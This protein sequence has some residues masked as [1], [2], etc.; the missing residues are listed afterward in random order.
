MARDNGA[1]LKGLELIQDAQPVFSVRV[2]VGKDGEEA[3]DHH[4]TGKEDLIFLDVNGGISARVSRPNP[5]QPSRHSTQIEFY[6]AIEENIGRPRPCVL[7][8]RFDFRS[9]L[10][11]VMD[12]LGVFL[13]YLF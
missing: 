8:Q 7:P 1:R 3:I 6:L 12:G 10:A 11:E 13:R 5:K 4:V 9:P 2:T